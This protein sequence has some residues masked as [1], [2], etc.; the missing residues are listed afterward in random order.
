MRRNPGFR[1][2]PSLIE[3]RVAELLASIGLKAKRH[4]ARLPAE[5]S[6]GQQLRAGLARALMPDRLAVMNQGRIA[7][8]GTPRAM[9]TEIEDDCLGRLMA[10]A[11]TSGVNQRSR[12]MNRGRT[13]LRV[14]YVFWGV[15]GRYA[16]CSVGRQSRKE[17]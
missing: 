15:Q 2:G 8:F 3:N 4:G 10:M 16:S 7:A 5:L 13:V 11:S 1:T 6:E 12:G 9:L 17:V 14:G